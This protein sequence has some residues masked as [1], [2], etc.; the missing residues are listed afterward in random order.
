MIRI[1][2]VDDEHT[3]RRGLELSIPWKEHGFEV[4]ATAKNGIDA[5]DFFQTNYADIIIS[6]IRMPRMD[7]L[8]LQEQIKKKYPNIPFIFLSGY[9]DF[10]YARKA[11][12]FG[13]FAY[14]LKPLDTNELLAELKRACERYNLKSENIPLKQ[15]I[16][17]NF[18]GLEKRWDFTNYEYLEVDYQNN[19]FCVLNIRCHMDDM[20]SQLFLMAFQKKLQDVVLDCFTQDNSALI[21]SS[22]RGIIFCVM[23]S[24]QDILKYTINT[25]V[26]AIS[27]KL[28]DYATTPLGIWTGGV[29]RGITRLIDSYVESFENASYKYFN[30]AKETASYDISFDTYSHLFDKEDTI[31]AALYKGD[32]IEAKTILN[33]QKDF[34]LKNRLSADDARLY[35]RHLLHKYLRAIKADDPTLALP[36]EIRSYGLFSML[37][38]SEMFSKLY[39]CIEITSALTKPVSLSHTDQT[40][41]TV[42]EYIAAHYSDPYLS[43]SSIADYVGLNPSY[44]STEFTKKEKIGLSN[45]ITDIRMEHAKKLLLRTDMIVS[46]VSKSTGYINPTYFSTAFKKIT[47]MTPSQ[48]RKI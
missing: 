38:I 17:R 44:L 47:G 34:L 45:Y 15:I 40:I 29:Y 46:D 11:L 37:T 33:D 14:L 16:E 42:K 31:I 21:E 18:Y 10:D 39:E 19:Y 27:I 23:N 20:R 22:S 24:N 8:A 6:D 2:I 9:E 26:N 12:Q 5:L 35:L 4:V 7:G 41:D 3:I 36:E 48:Y 32:L 13:A 30:E 25:F 43:L 1:L 28:D